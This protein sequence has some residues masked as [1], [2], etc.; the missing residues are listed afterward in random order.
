MN[1]NGLVGEMNYF[2]NLLRA[3]DSIPNR[4]I[5]PV[6]VTSTKTST[7]FTSQLPNWQIIRSRLVERRETLYLV[8]KIVERLFRRSYFIEQLLRK[9]KISVLSHARALEPGSKVASIGWIPDFQHMRRP[10]FFRPE[11]QIQRD[12]DFR[13]DLKIWTKVIVSSNDARRDL[14][15]FDKQSLSKSKVLQFVS[16]CGNCVP[17]LEDQ[18]N[19]RKKYGIDGPYFHLP[20]QFWAHKNHSVVI[21]AL[22]KLK[23][24]GKR[25]LVVAT[26]MTF[27]PRHPDFYETLMKEV[28][29]AG[30]GESFKTPGVIPYQDMVAIMKGSIAVINPSHFEGWSTSVEEAKSMG[31]QIL[32]SDIPVHREQSPERAHYFAQHNENELVELIAKVSSEYSE[33]ME[34]GWQERAF[35]ELPNRFQIFGASYQSIVEEV[36]SET[37]APHLSRVFQNAK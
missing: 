26:G 4:T 3:I 18:Q 31:K 28:A 10:D 5:E 36:A 35:K 17:T 23:M 12:R 34:R 21:K 25:I 24:A 20:N 6:I 19:V 33:E 8:R 29:T 15:V 2:A 14:E 1:K 37:L 13:K 30:L 22:A 9:H 27:D 16:S 32:L 7:E 11:E